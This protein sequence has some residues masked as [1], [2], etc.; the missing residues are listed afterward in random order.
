M[1]FNYL[2]AVSLILAAWPFYKPSISEVKRVSWPSRGSL[3]KNAAVVFAF[4]LILSV[5]FIF[6]DWIFGYVI[7]LFEWL[8]TKI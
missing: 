5:F 8:S 4:I 2:G 6:S 3:L 1:D 7:D